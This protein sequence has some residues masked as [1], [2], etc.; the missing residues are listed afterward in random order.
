M[1]DILYF[2]A[3]GLVTFLWIFIFALIRYVSE[4]KNG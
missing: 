1:T 3:G 4:V 2:I